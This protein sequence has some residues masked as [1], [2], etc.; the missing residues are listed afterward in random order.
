LCLELFHIEDAVRA[1]FIFEG[2][3]QK[4]WE[5]DGNYR[6]RM[7]TQHSLYTSKELEGSRLMG[8]AVFIGVARMYGFHLSEISDYLGIEPSLFKD[9]IALYDRFLGEAIE[10]KLGG[11]E[12]PITSKASKVYQKTC[13]LR[14]FVTRKYCHVL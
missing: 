11:G 14:N 9:C 3:E 5:S 6:E 1:N 8:L 13:L 10:I 12:V 4:P 2:R 7:A